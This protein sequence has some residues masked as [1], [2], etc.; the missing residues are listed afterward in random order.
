[1]LAKNESDQELLNQKI[2]RILLFL[3]IPACG[4]I[5][6]GA[7]Y[8]GF[9][10]VTLIWPYLMLPP[11][12]GVVIL[13]LIAGTTAEHPLKCSPSLKTELNKLVAPAV[14]ILFIAA[15]GWWIYYLATYMEL[16]Q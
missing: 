8:L 2:Y 9:F 10:Q 14:I 5:S 6:A 15:F 1:M 3:T 13:V 4:F 12:L 16:H 11:S 7:A